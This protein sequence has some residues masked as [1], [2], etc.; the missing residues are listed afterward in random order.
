MAGSW[1]VADI[2]GF[3]VTMRGIDCRGLGC[4]L[5][6]SSLGMLLSAC[7]P[8]ALP[9]DRDAVFA[10]AVEHSLDDEPELSA[11]GRGSLH[12]H[13]FAGRPAF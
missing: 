5:I 6:A 13:G 10:L 11:R 3:E 4:L 2:L 9:E 1:N 12:G 8:A 7:G